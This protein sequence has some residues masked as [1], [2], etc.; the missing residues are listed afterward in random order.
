MKTL[1]LAVLAVIFVS[2]T[3]HATAPAN[4]CAVSA[5]KKKDLE[6][7]PAP[8][9]LRPGDTIPT[10]TMKEFFI[11]ETDPNWHPEMHRK[12]VPIY[13]TPEQRK[14]YEVSFANGVFM[15]ADGS[16]LVDPGNLFNYVM[17]GNG[18][19]YVFDQVGHDEIR[20]SSIFDGGPV[21]GAGELIVDATGHLTAINI[22][23]GHY[24]Q[25]QDCLTNILNQLTKNGIDLTKVQ[26]VKEGGFPWLQFFKKPKAS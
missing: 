3:T 23:S 10:V 14:V 15:K 1:A 6:P 5:I 18:N 17:D 25:T 22:N 11:G 4:S 7:P 13:M 20:H 2:T 19:F 8:P 9:V 24:P 21:A 12:V 26:I 16:V